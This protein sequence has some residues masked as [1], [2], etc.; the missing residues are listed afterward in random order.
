MMNLYGVLTELGADG[1][2]R[3]AVVDSLRAA[4]GHPSFW[5]HPYTCDGEQVPGLPAL[6]APQQTLFEMVVADEIT[7][8][9]DWI[10]TP[11]LFADAIGT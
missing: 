11:A 4:V 5:G 9:S 8:V 7:F 2:S 1:I 3:E 10:D 6:C